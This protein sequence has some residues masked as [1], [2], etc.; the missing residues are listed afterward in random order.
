MFVSK[1]INKQGIYAIKFYMN[2]KQVI[3][4]VDDFIPVRNGNEP[5]FVKSFDRHEIWPII[6]EKAWSKLL[7]SYANTEGGLISWVMR[8]LTDDAVHHFK[9][10]ENIRLGEKLASWNGSGYPV[11]AFS[12]KDAYIKHHVVSVIKVEEGRII[13]HNP[14]G[15]SE[16][17]DKL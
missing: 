12:R 5:A 16:W 7:G 14:W 6:I 10:T 13:M 8:Y 3:V 9:I 2:G 15:Y 1:K 4:H 17:K 11:F